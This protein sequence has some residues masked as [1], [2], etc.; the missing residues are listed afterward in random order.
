[1]FR[2]STLLDRGASP[3]SLKSSGCHNPSADAERRSPQFVFSRPRQGGRGRSIRGMKMMFNALASTASALLVA[4]VFWGSPSAGT[5][6]V[7][8]S[9]DATALVLGA[10]SFPTPNQ[11]I[12]DWTKDKY[13]APVYSGR[14]IDIEYIPVTTPQEFWPITGVFRVIGP[15]LA[16]VDPR[17]SPKLIA[18]Q[19]PDGMPLWKLS[20]LFD[21][22]ADQSIR[23]GA[24]ILEAR[25]A[26]QLADHPGEPIIVTGIS[27][28][29][30]VANVVKARLA[31]KYAGDPNPPDIDFVLAGDPNLPNG[32]LL[33]RFDGLY[34]PILDF[35]F[36]GPAPSD[37]P[38]ETVEIFRQYDGFTDFPLYPINVVS[39][40]NALFGLIFVHLYLGEVSLPEDPEINS[41]AFVGKHGDTSYYFFRSENL[42]L[43]EPL[44]IAGVPESVI[45]VFEPFVREIVELGYDR[46]IKPWE[47]TPARLIPRLDPA[48]VAT[49]LVTAATEGI[50]NA[51]ALVSPPPISP[52]PVALVSTADEPQNASPQ[53]EVRSTAEVDTAT[54][55][56]MTA[57]ERVDTSIQDAPAEPV[58]DR[59][60]SVMSEPSA[61]DSGQRNEASQPVK[62]RVRDSSRAEPVKPQ[63]RNPLRAEPVRRQVRGSLRVEPSRVDEG[64][65][66]MTRPDTADNEADAEDAGEDSRSSSDASSAGSDSR[67]GN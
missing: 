41:P 64:G 27:Q 40:V 14:D 18:A 36:S 62:S 30:G 45:D 26:Q 16:A 10:T 20:G 13:V 31:E 47:P 29:A 19:F 52:A 2:L 15:A 65:V 6:Q 24:D 25:I 34:I 1:M 12:I 37:T 5:P 67:S 50:H 32:G 49:D 42:P 22:T 3:A 66:G 57:T 46:S 39:D 54:T 44:R 56:A 60:A 59:S 17:I 38:F 55:A 35:S 51:T 63:V 8:L 23:K 48:K 21:L 53:A 33:S 4:T 61:T 9:A 43:F 7:E 11:F 28:G 58:G